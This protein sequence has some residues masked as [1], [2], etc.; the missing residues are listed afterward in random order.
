MFLNFFWACSF[1]SRTLLQATLAL[2]NV[3]WNSITI[4]CNQGP[5]V[6]ERI[7]LLQ[8]LMG[9]WVKCLLEVHKAHMEW[10]LLLA[11]LAHQYAEICDLLCC[12][13]SLSESHL[14]ICNFCFGLHLD[15]FQYDPKKNLACMSDKSNCSVICTLFQ[16]TFLK[17][18]DERGERL[19]LWPLASFYSSPHKFYTFCPVLSLFF[20]QFSWDLI[21]TCGFA[22]CCV[23]DGMSNLWMKW[24]R[25]L[26]SIFL[27]NSFLFF[28]TVLTV[29]VRMMSTSFVVWKYVDD[30]HGLLTYVTHACCA[31]VELT[32]TMYATNMHVVE[33][34][35]CQLLKVLLRLTHHLF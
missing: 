2:F 30:T 27:F 35:T 13:P 5:K 26:L 16:I 22:T 31:V 20:D 34:K 32:R 11:C 12:A 19:F 29:M 9:D 17:K 3:V 33:C 15:P 21:S 28:I 4:F 14:F 24:W 7:H 6:W 25:L 18:W 10:L 8:L 23:T 1:N